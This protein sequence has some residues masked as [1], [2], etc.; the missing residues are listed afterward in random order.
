MRVCVRVRGRCELGRAM[1]PTP[2]AFPV[3]ALTIPLRP[4]I[5][6]VEAEREGKVKGRRE[7]EGAINEKAPSESGTCCDGK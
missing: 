5:L 4:L 6:S 2:L 7:G 1:I 3:T